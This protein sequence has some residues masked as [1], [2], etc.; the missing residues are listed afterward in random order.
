LPK[1]LSPEQRQIARQAYAGLLWSKQFY[2]YIVRDWLEGDPQMPKPPRNG[3]TAA[4][5]IGGMST[6]V[7]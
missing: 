3:R 4:T 6:I 7:T 5:P 2:H 1:A